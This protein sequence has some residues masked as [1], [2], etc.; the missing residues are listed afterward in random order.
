M[1]VAGGAISSSMAILDVP[2]MSSVVV[3]SS[4]SVKP[5]LAMVGSD[6]REVV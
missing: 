6:S 4:S 1:L 3:G 5:A 2:F